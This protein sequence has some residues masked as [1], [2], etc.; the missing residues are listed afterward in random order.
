MSRFFYALAVSLALILPLSLIIPIQIFASN[1]GEFSL[2]F[3]NIE[4]HLFIPALVAAFC[5]GLV[6]LALPK[7][8]FNY[9]IAVTMALAWAVYLQANIL[10]WDYGLFDGSEIPW[11]TLSRRSWVDGAVWLILIF[12]ALLF[13]RR[14]AASRVLVWTL[15]LLQLFNGLA[16]G[17]KISG[18]WLSAGTQP[19]LNSLSQFSSRRNVIFIV[20]DMFQSPA[21]E[22]ILEAQPE[23]RQKFRDF[24][25]YRN[26]LASFSTTSPSIP[27]IL[28]GQAYDNSAPIKDYLDQVLPNESLPSV[29]HKL[30]YQV[31][32]ITSEHYCRRIGAASCTTA[33]DYTTAG[34]RAKELSEAGKLADVSLFRAAPQPIK[35]LI[36]NDQAWFLQ[37]RRQTRSGPQHHLQSIDFVERMQSQARLGSEKETFK[38]FHLMIP[39]LPLRL[40]PECRFS[41]DRTGLT[42]PNYSL[43]ARC[44]LHLTDLLLEKFRELGVYDSA[45]IVVLS[46][47][48]LRLNFRE[49]KKPGGMI[50]IG[51]GLP[52]LLI[53][54]PNQQGPLQV[55]AAPAMLADLP[56]TVAE[57]L[58]INYTFPGENLFTLPAGQP[59]QRTFRHYRWNKD[60]WQQ[61][62]LPRM[63]EYIVQGDAWKLESW[64]KK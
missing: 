40:D 10:V 17:V 51:E 22:Y 3:L 28:T 4:R 49:H 19:Q 46:D 16:A 54:Q 59:R 47:H 18:K 24:V 12:G 37:A 48:G 8:W 14:I 36:F 20:L 60:D 52:L 53:K 63:D 38:F 61:E 30:G 62:Y 57:F 56:R 11:E 5:Y 33:D 21:F 13:A 25:Y 32:L 45:L 6:A 50:E 58:G 39:H 26:A 9:L 41:N 35:R 2:G 55:S 64:K 44:A 27:V 34:P 15:L 43:Q 1:Q 31:D 7:G 29:L 42:M 23:V